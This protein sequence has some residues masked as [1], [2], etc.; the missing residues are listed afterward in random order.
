[1]N[2]LT[3]GNYCCFKTCR[4]WT[5]WVWHFNKT[6]K[7]NSSLLHAF[8]AFPFT[9]PFSNCHKYL[10]WFLLLH[11]PETYPKTAISVC[12][13]N[14]YRH[15]KSLIS[16]IKRG[17]IKLYISIVTFH[18]TKSSLH[19]V[20]AFNRSSK[21]W[22]FTLKRLIDIPESYFRNKTGGLEHSVKL[23]KMNLK[24]KL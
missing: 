11:G 3:L 5:F 19:I 7:F 17:M 13:Y 14:W 23:H 15:S 6:V 4:L 24:R 8:K 10:T 22:N 2:V 20:L 12:Y 21:K 18:A 16:K 9:P 1:M